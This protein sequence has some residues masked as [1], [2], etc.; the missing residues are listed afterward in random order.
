MRLHGETPLDTSA[1]PFLSTP[2]EDLEIQHEAL[3]STILEE[4]EQV[5]T[6]HRQHID[7]IM[8]LVKQEME[9]LQEVCPDP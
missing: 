1:N 8:V 7:D 3:I 9:A 6:S 4:E 5:I 2:Q